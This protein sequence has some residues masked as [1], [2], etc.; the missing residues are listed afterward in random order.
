MLIYPA[1]LWIRTVWIASIRFL[2]DGCF[3]QP[4]GCLAGF[5]WVV[6]GQWQPVWSRPAE[7]VGLIHCH[8]NDVAYFISVDVIESAE[9]I[10]AAWNQLNRS[11]LM[12]AF[13]QFLRW[14]RSTGSQRLSA[15][16]AGHLADAS[17]NYRHRRSSLLLQEPQFQVNLFSLVSSSFHSKFS[18]SLTIIHSFI[19][20]LALI[21]PSIAN[22]LP[23]GLM[24]RRCDQRHLARRL[25]ISIGLARF[26]TAI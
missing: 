19:H 23:V 16:R 7:S 10:P 25:L 20:L 21:N 15:H 22:K 26:V 18:H 1:A 17:Q 3:R 12:L 5:D 24:L 14:F 9:P 8:C 13:L 2:S 6:L 11:W 4:T